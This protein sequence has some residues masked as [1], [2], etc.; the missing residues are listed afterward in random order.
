MLCGDPSSDAMLKAALEAINYMENAPV[1]RTAGGLPVWD[2]ATSRG[3]NAITVSVPQ[4]TRHHSSIS[5]IDLP[6]FK[7]SHTAQC[8]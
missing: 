3:R 8:E 5:C 2:A 6:L 7:D 4:D 1:L